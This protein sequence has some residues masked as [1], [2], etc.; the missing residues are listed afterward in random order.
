MRRGSVLC[1]IRGAAPLRCL[2][3]LGEAGIEAKRAE[4]ADEFTLRLTLDE[5]DYSAAAAIAARSQCELARISSR[6]GALL[7]RRLRRRIALLT[8]AV[9]CFALLAAGSLFVW[10]ID[11]SGCESVTEGEV[12]RALASAGVAEGSFWPAWDA[13]AV[14]NHL[15]LEIPELA[16]AGVS[17]SGSRAEVRVRE[18]IERPE[19]ASDG[20]PGSIT[21]AA[22]GIIERMEVYE[23]APA[24]SVGDAVAVGETLVSGE[25][26]SA[27]GDTRYVRARAAVT[28]RTYVE[29][30]ACAPL[31]YGRLLEADTHSRWSLIIGSGRV[32]F[33]RGS[34]QTPPGCGKIIEEY[35]L[36]WEGVFRLPVTLVRE[37][38]IEYS[39]QEAEE[40][41]ALLEQRLAEA[42]Q[43]RLERRLEGRGEALSV[44]FTARESGGALYVTLRAECREDIAVYTP[45]EGSE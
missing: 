22:S 36:A 35:P 30:T 6:G 34:S 42:L 10:E 43:S 5:R 23:G 24:V 7:A 11:I 37:T 39:A 45:A 41:P 14:K 33:F 40:D 32:N 29:L 17:V 13:D 27:V 25:M 1:E 15:L 20:A 19:L 8:A 21:A 2:N 44:H 31:K 26:A 28:A 4:R 18:R 38:V 3:A 9:V 16:W 12:R